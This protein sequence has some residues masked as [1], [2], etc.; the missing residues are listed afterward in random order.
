M[1]RRMFT[2]GSTLLVLLFLVLPTST[3]CSQDSSEE[4]DVYDYAVSTRVSITFGG[5]TVAQFVE[6]LNQQAEGLNVLIRADVQNIQLPMLR[7]RNVSADTALNSLTP[8]SLDALTV[9]MDDSQ[10]YYIIGPN[11]N[12]EVDSVE[13]FN[14]G[15]FLSASTEERAR[16]KQETLLSTI[17]AGQDMLAT[18]SGTMKIYLH[19]ETGLLFV[20]GSPE[21]TDL[22]RQI[23]KELAA[24]QEHHQQGTTPTS[25]QQPKPG[26]PDTDGSVK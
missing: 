14:V 24:A 11:Y 2:P 16:V 21:E 12:R 8:L 22:V 20:K 1:Q 13:V 23:V 25:D 15:W 26:A 17:E 4:Q 19:V 9:E 10:S 3:L 18:S 6:Q 7:L 5:G